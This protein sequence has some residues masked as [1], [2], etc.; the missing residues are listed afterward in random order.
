MLKF[1]LVGLGKIARDQHLPSIER[2]PGAELVAVAS[3]NAQAGGL[4]NYPDIAT[5][6]VE[7]PDL[8]AVILCQ[9]PRV[10][11]GAARLALNAGKHVFLEKPP[12]VSVS[13]VEA[14]VALAQ[15]RG[16]TL[17]ASWHSRYAAAVRQARNWLSDKAIRRASIAWKEDVRHWHP[18]QA[19]IWEAGGF[20]VFDPGINALS[21]LTGIA[22]EPI[23]L[24]AAD[25]EM[26]SNRHAP[27]GATLTLE[28]AS[29]API[30]AMFDW[31]QTGPQTW[32]IEVE[33]DRGTLLLSHGG[34]NLAIDGAAQPV[35]AEEEYPALYRHF[36]ELIANRR[37]D[38]DV[39]PLQLVADA[40]LCAR[41]HLTDVFED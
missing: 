21:I 25:L 22:P 36:A 10:R 40:F 1:G 12:G 30:D 33:T 38:V 5:M 4:A 13:E 24:A 7:H 20:G 11:Y 39:R 34:N 35:G 6:L 14:L 9:P 27:I 41:F 28:T 8:D 23:R 2:T 17:F 37:S 19:W 16:V 26:P 29:G 18:G 32:D 15:Q 3:R 31:R